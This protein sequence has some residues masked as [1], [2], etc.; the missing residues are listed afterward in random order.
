M[1]SENL[2]EASRRLSDAVDRL[3]FA[4]PVTHV[5]NPLRYAQTCWEEYLARFAESPKRIVFVGMNPGPWGMAQTGVPFGE[6]AAV[7]EWMQI[8]RIVGVPQEQH[9]KRPVEGFACTRSEVSGRRLWGL[10][11]E[12]FITADRFFADSFVANYCP[13]VFLAERRGWI[14]SCR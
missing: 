9:P 5:Y 1:V 11:Q 10:M 13:L 6:I 14:P 8:E 3:T 7:R 12:R 2:V 4:A